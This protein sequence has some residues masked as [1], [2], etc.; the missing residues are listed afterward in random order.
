MQASGIATLL[1]LILGMGIIG[2]LAMPMFASVPVA[3]SEETINT[4]EDL[5]T[6]IAEAFGLGFSTMEIGLLIGL[7]IGVII[8][9]WKVMKL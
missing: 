3:T 8:F 7:L 5:T 4:T 9:I 6:P 2:I 1:I